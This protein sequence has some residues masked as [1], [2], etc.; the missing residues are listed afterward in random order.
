MLSDRKIENR[1]L[2]SLAPADFAE[3]ADG[4]HAIT[5]PA[6]QI[7]YEVGS[8]LDHIYF[9]EEGLASVLTIMEDGASSEVGM[10]G[11]EGFLGMGALLGGK[12][13]AQHIVIQLPTAAYRIA[14]ATCKAVFESNPR[15]RAVL[16]SFV[17]D[18]LNLSAQI[19]GCNRLHSVAQRSARWLLMASDRASSNALPLTQEFLATMLGVRRSGVSEAMGELQRD[20]LVSYR[21]GQITI[22]DRPSLEETACECYSLDRQ[23]VGRMH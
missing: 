18:M 11:P 3:L 1:L 7:V 20:G 19:A 8:P 9:I 10:V 21:R 14:A 4:L 12:I 5:L 22:V 15:V 17:E 2:A 16:L 6:R 23:R 13:S